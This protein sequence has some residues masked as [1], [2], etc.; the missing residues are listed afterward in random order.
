MAIVKICYHNFE[1]KKNQRFQSNI[2]LFRCNSE[3]FTQEIQKK[4]YRTVCHTFSFCALVFIL[5][6][7]NELGDFERLLYEM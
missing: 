7:M 2:D 4:E 6:Q 1:G 3:Y 5:Q